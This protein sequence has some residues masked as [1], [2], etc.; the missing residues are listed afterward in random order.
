MQGACVWVHARHHSHYVILHMLQQKWPR[1]DDT[2]RMLCYSIV[3]DVES[4][5]ALS[6]APV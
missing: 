1:A 2:L 3:H 4:V 6:H 5:T